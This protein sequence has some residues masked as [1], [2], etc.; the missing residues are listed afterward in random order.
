MRGKSIT[1]GSA[2]DPYQ[3]AEAHF[4]LTQGLLRVFAQTRGLTLSITTKSALVKRDIHLFR[5]ISEHNDFRVNISLISLDKRLVRTLEPKY[6]QPAARLEALQKITAA[7]VRAGIFLM[8]ILPVNTDSGEN[9]DSVISAAYRNGAQ[10][11]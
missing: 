11:V 2:T 10:Y 5:T 8:P 3:H 9:L 1:I 7:G 4:R 6:S